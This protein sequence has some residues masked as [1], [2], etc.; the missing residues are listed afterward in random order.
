MTSDACDPVRC[1]FFSEG[2]VAFDLFPFRGLTMTGQAVRVFITPRIFDRVRVG[3]RDVVHPMAK[4]ITLP[5]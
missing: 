5:S 2:L 3:I 4:A 1:E